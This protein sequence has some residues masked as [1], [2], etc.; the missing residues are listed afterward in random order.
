MVQDQDFCVFHRLYGN[1]AG[2]LIEKAGI[3][4][5][6]TFIEREKSGRLNAIDCLIIAEG[7]SSGKAD[8]P[9]DLAFGDEMLSFPVTTE[10]QALLHIVPGRVVDLDELQEEGV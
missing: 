1:E 10:L 4:A 8:L 7:A 5:Y 6:P 2:G 3:R 9:A